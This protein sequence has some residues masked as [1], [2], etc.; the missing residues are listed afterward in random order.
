MSKFVARNIKFA[1]DDQVYEKLH[2]CC[3]YEGKKI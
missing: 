2:G 3:K 1:A